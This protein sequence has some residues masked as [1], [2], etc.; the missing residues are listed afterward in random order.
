MKTTCLLHLTTGLA[1]TAIFCCGAPGAHATAVPITNSSFETNVIAT[2]GG[3]QPNATGWTT[4]TGNT[5]SG[6]GVPLDDTV[7]TFNPTAAQFTGAGG[8]AGVA[9]NMAGPQALLMQTTLIGL[10][11]SVSQTTGTLLTLNSTYTL[12]VAVGNP[13][14]G[15]FQGYLL[16]LLAGTNTLATQSLSNVP[17]G[18][19]V[20]ESLSFLAGPAVASLV[21]LPVTVVL[22]APPSV[23]A[24]S[25]VAFDNVQLDVETVPEP[26]PAK[27]VAAGLGLLCLAGFVKSRRRLRGGWYA[28][29]P[30]GFSAPPSTR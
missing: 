1:A 21:N 15:S 23:V 12:T 27:A 10:G 20:N 3:T 22:S 24:G 19:F 9:P 11:G 5:L 8:L 28:P 25:A 6:L 18:T 26:N 29:T 16:S 14:T 7:S 4:V 2:D 30:G 13:G 17:S